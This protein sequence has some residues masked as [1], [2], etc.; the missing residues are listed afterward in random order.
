MYG[1]LALIAVVIADLILIPW[2]ADTRAWGQALRYRGPVAFVMVPAI[3]ALIVAL[4]R[5]SD[6]TSA[7]GPSSAMAAAAGHA[8][9]PGSWPGVVAIATASGFALVFTIQA[10]AWRAA[11]GRTADRLAAAAPGCVAIETLGIRQFGALDHWG[12][13][14]TLLVLDGPAPAHVTLPSRNCGEASDRADIVVR[15]RAG[16]AD[17]VI[18]AGR[19]GW[20]NLAPLEASL[21]P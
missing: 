4:L 9:R 21:R 13:T 14:A 19:A 20:W 18:A 17:D 8:E 12:L 7:L 10:L 11:L 15:V 5:P 2:A 3:L 6:T 1:R 16:Q